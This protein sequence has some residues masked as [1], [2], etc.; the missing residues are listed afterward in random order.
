M[1]ESPFPTLTGRIIEWNAQKGYG[2]IQDGSKRIFLHRRD[3]AQMHKRPVV[4]DV[5][6]FTLGKDSKGRPCAT[7]ASHLND[8][9]RI[10]VFAVILVA[11]LL[12]LPSLAL[13][14]KHV[15]LRWPGLY[16][17]ALSLVSYRCYANDKRKAQEKD[18]RIPEKFLQLTALLGG[19]PGAFLAQR[20]FRHKVAKPGFQFIFWL[21]VFAYQLTAV[22]ALRNWQFSKQAWSYI[23]K[24]EMQHR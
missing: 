12:I 3:F 4:G 15:D 11:A 9:G 2:F 19:W 13:I 17:L 20:H 7:N 10:T 1:P 22:D 8:G 18:W 14:H 6:S 16:A 5:I 23:Q 21:I 24:I